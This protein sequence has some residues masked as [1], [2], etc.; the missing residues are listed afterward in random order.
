MRALSAAMI[1]TAGAAWG[2]PAAPGPGA[3]MDF[4]E[5]KV[6]PVLV[7]NCY[8]CHSREA[9]AAQG[10]FVLDSREGL[11]LGGGSGPAVV[12][13]KPGESV[14]IQAIR[15]EGKLKMPPFGKL[16]DAVIADLT[17][18]VEMGAPDPRVEKAAPAHTYSEMDLQKGREFWAFQ[19]PV[20]PKPPRPGAKQRA[21]VRGDIDRF[22]AAGYAAEGLTPVADADRRTLIRRVSLD[23]TGLPPTPAEVDAFVSDK[24]KGAFE[25]V[26][27]RLLASEA[28]G[29]RWGRHW[30]DVARYAETNGR[31]RN[32]PFPVAWRY[33]DYVIDSFNADKPYDRFVTEQ[34]AG[35][36]LPAKGT[37]ERNT[38]LIAT[39]FL[40]LGAHDLNEQDRRQNE[41]DRIDEQINVTTKAFLGL[42]VG[43]ARCHD[44]KFDPI[45]TKDYYALAGIFRSTSMLSGLRQ[46]PQ[47]NAVYSDPALYAT[48]EGVEGDS[49]AT[50]ARRATLWDRAMKIERQ[51]GRKDRLQ[52]RQV[53][54][55]L[56]KLPVPGNYAMAVT[57]G[58]PQSCQVNLRGDAHALGENVP[59][60]FVQVVYGERAQLP[61]IPGDASGRLQLAE[62]L[63]R[64]DN[65]LTAR[66]MVNR[67]WQHL[68]GQGIVDTVDNFGKSGSLPTN[69]QLLDYL[70]V[71]FMDQGWSVKKTVREIVLS[72]TYQL[73][74]THQ[75]ANFAKDPESRRL[76]RMPRLR[77]E[78]EAIRDSVLAVSGKLDRS[79]PDGSPVFRWNVNAEANR[80][81]GGRV[82]PWERTSNHRSVYLPVIRNAGS[83]FFETFDFPE[84]SETRG[85]R[86][87]TTVPTQALFLL[88]DPFVREQAKNAARALVD[89]QKTDRARAAMAYKRTLARGPDARELDRALSYVHQAREEA[90]G[91]DASSSADE[92]EV[93]AWTRFY[94]A[95]MASA[96][97]RY[98]Y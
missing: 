22:I 27:D 59:R 9:K 35:D 44:H 84:P 36:L 80:G 96:E 89:E 30:L 70:A 21:W 11:R 57:E 12:E 81:Q 52:L 13:G 93:E 94:Q 82:Q 98:R 40:A 62:W 39:G 26:V 16:P 1:L 34:L 64:R 20:A 5:S 38:N 48:L 58:K 60:G 86:D 25:R 77:L 32:Y 43:C 28:Y 79:R 17:R 24:K 4:F 42:T 78:A 49:E 47:F 46:R 85:Q 56:G 29:E 2:Q 37:G 97:F 8:M 87:V 19:A 66:V 55:Q 6:R 45:P 88:N 50:A 18:W 54:L 91:D 61:A 75:A 65:P 33:R 15:Q 63:V 68:F 51:R 92:A 10:G 76:W 53:A 3:G 23:L 74:G 41:M 14:L 90:S 95:L 69:R 71:R 31:T 83:R 67:V 72:R 73:G 7:K